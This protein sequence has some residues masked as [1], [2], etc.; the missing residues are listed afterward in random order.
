MMAPPKLVNS[1]HLLSALCGVAPDEAPAPAAKVTHTCRS[2]QPQRARWRPQRALDRGEVS[3]GRRQES[4][5]LANSVEGFIARTPEELLE[6]LRAQLSEPVTGLPDEQRLIFDPTNR[7]LPVTAPGTGFNART[8]LLNSIFFIP[9]RDNVLDGLKRQQSEVWYYRFDWDQE[10]APFNDIYGA[11]HA[12][13][14]AFVFGNFGPS[15]FSK[16]EFSTANRPGRLELSEAMMQSLGRSRAP[17]TR[18]RRRSASRGRC[19]RR[20]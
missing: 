2:V 18:T 13:D 12:F 9:S 20:C 16:I 19:G 6:F 1:D 10:P 7:Y 3:A 11:A 15:L 8:D 4:R 17:A 5:L 14:L